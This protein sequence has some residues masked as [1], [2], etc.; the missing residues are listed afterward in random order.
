[1][2]KARDLTEGIMGQFLQFDLRNGSLR[3]SEG[4]AAMLREAGREDT[5][6]LSCAYACPTSAAQ[7]QRMLPRISRPALPAVSFPP[8]QSTMPSSTLSRSWRTRCTS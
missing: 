6:L 4:R 7:L 8:A 3:K 1:M 2:Q 5:C